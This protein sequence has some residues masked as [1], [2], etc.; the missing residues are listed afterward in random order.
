MKTLS[1]L[2]IIIFLSCSSNAKKNTQPKQISETNS[3]SFCPND[4][5]CSFELF[6]NK[7]LDLN[8]DGIGQLYP[9]ISNGNAT[10]YKFT[11]TKNK[12]DR[13]QDNHYSEEVYF[14]LPKP[15]D[16]LVIK[17]KALSSVKLVFARLCFCRGQTGYYTINEGKLIIT[18]LKTDTYE[19][20]L[21]FKTDEVPQV[22][23]LIKETILN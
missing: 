2:L 22:I 7:K 1:C 15:I 17:N 6:K 21:S 13:Y 23:S 14:E 8:K 16:E 9:K 3:K 10:V 11:Y 18:K 12:D 20:N 19:I 5:L 4:G